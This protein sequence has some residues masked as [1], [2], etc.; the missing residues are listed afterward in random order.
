[1]NF[2][3]L[4]EPICGPLGSVAPAPGPVRPVIQ[5]AEIIMMLS[6]FSLSDETNENEAHLNSSLWISFQKSSHRGYHRNLGKW[7]IS[8]KV[9]KVGVSF[10]QLISLHC[11]FVSF[12][13]T[14][15]LNWVC[16]TFKLSL[17]LIFVFFA[18]LWD[19]VYSLYFQSCL[20]MGHWCWVC[21]VP[22]HFSMQ[23]M[24]KQW[25]HSPQTWK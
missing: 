22:S 8:G 6:S 17:S 10:W 1:M 2:E 11:I 9:K 23:W 15:N 12:D 4:L 14:L 20:H 13:V 3:P 21:W 5:M 24:W 25:V 18:F 19:V 7:K 16:F